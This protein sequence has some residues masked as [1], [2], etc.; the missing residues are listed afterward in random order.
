MTERPATKL[1]ILI[2]DDEP[3]ARFGMAKALK[4]DHHEIIEARSG[5]ETLQR[6]RD[7]A[8]HLVFLDLNMPEKDGLSVLRTSRREGFAGEIVVV[9]ADDQVTMAVECMRLGASDYITKPFEV[10][11][12]RNPGGRSWLPLRSYRPDR[13]CPPDRCRIHPGRRYHRSPDYRS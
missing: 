9:T 5:E 10:E 7:R 3:A 2:A 11:N 4:R 8:P 6:L 1:R 12:P 13:R